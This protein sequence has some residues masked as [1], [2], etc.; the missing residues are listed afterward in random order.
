MHGIFETPVGSQIYLKRL[1]MYI[2]I[3]IE[4]NIVNNWA[5]KHEI[6]HIERFQITTRIPTL[7]YIYMWIYAYIST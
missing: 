3:F 5:N 6:P 7:V 1:K 2:K 4:V